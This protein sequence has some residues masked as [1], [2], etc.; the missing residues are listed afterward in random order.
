MDCPLCGYAMSTL[1]DQC[2]RCLGRGRPA[3]GEHTSQ[4]AHSSPQHQASAAIKKFLNEEQDA[5]AV[6]QAYDRVSQVLTTGEEILYIAV[7]KRPLVNISPGSAVLTNKRFIVYQPNMLGGARFADY[8]WRDLSDARL[9]EGLAGST[10]T[11]QTVRGLI[12]TIQYLPKSQA[13]KLYSFAQQMEEQARVDRRTH[14]LEDK[15]AAA[16][17]IVLQGGASPVTL[18]S[19]T[20]PTAP[21]Q[22]DPLQQ[23][24][25]LKDMFDAG[26]ISDEEFASKKADILSRL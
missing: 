2:P 24:K 5:L 19:T 3:R 4:S 18:P 7:Q 21:A 20:V 11:M 15:R 17:G 13:R 25:I 23:M 1:D 14:S 22:P 10:L 12:L 16:G 6:E 9:V 26:F 8:I